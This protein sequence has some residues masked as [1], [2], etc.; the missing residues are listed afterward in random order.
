MS[1]SDKLRDPRWQKKRLAI[2]SRAQ[3]QCEECGSDTE[4]LHV[5]HI[6]YIAGRDPW[7]YDDRDLKC[8]CAG[9]HESYH[10]QKENLLVIFNWFPN[11]PWRDKAV[12]AIDKVLEEY[13]SSVVRGQE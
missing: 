10:E 5:H 8:V 11:K 3:F 7:D 2:M 12:D 13:E 9:C 6:S 4:T 1:Y